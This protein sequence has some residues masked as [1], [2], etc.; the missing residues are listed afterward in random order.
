MKDFL[1]TVLACLVAMVVACGAVMFFFLVLIGILASAGEQKVTIAKDSVLVFDLT[2]NIEDSPANESAEDLVAQIAGSGGPGRLQLRKTIAAIDAAAADARIK[3]LYL[4]GSISPANYG[5][6]YAALLEVRAAL[7]RFRA[8]GKPILAYLVAPTTRDYLLASAASRVVMHPMGLVLTPGLSAEVLYF[9]GLFQKYG[10]GV[11]VAKTGRYKSAAETFA[12][13]HMSEA[14][15]EQLTVLLDD[16]WNEYVAVVAQGRGL[17][18][19]ALQALIDSRGLID[20]DTAVRE[21]LVDAAGDFS[22]VLA[23]LKTLTGEE[24]QGKTFRQI[25]LPAYIGTLTPPTDAKVRKSRVAVVYAEGE[26]VDGEGRPQMVGGDNLAREL[27]K[28]R[29]DESIK[30]V[31]LRVNSPGGSA[32]ASEVIRR[33]VALLHEQKPVV[34][35]MGTVAASG[36]Y[37]ISTASDRIFAEPNTITGSIGVIAMIPNVQGL[38]ERLSLNFETVET[39]RL[40][41]IFSIARPRS[42]EAMAVVQRLVDATYVKFIDRVAESRE[43]SREAVEALAG[44]RVWSGADA[45]ENGLVDEIGGLDAAVRSAAGLAQLETYMVVDR[46]EARTFFEELVERLEKKGTPLAG[47]G[48]VPDLA[49]QLESNLALL[50]SL[51][52]PA[53]VYAL[54]PM[55]LELR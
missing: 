29:D 34:V 26:I 22:D 28:V 6:G 13:D 43:M 12:Q 47:R 30:A 25:A 32:I 5:S 23:E 7:E 27:R 17:E 53:G 55:R 4:H 54:L 40:A 10:I 33:E 42:D 2:A 50:Q 45:V 52:D 37:W 31:V 35:S 44:G 18:P 1:K 8:T 46:P 38:A 20:A 15:R 51:N 24:E 21:H 41:G 19:A 9:G 39:G 11:Q 14:E 48:P 49:R 16:I 36:G 3:G